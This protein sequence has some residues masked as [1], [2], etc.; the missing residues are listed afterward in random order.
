MQDI[1]AVRDEIADRIAARLGASIQKAEVAASLGKPTSDLTAYDYYLRGRSLRE[2]NRRERS[3][4]A[5]ALFEKAIELAPLFAPAIAELAYADYREVAL[6]WDPPHRE[7]VLARGLAYAKRALATDPALPLAHMVTGDLLLRRLTHD[8][9]IR[10]ARRAVE[11]NPSEAEY[12]AGLAN[13]LTFAGQ[14]DEA[15]SLM[16][17]AFVLDPLHPPNY[18]MYLARAL[19]LKQRFDEALPHLRDC[20]RRAP[21][22]WSCHLFAA[23]AYAHLGQKAAALSS[24][25]ELRRHSTIRSLDEFLGTGEYISRAHREL[26]REGLAKA[27]PPLT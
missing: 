6:R 25:E 19:L 26:I 21:D 8:E 23:V 14:A 17:R 7:K 15:V 12:H 18:D 20:A 27:G 24:V 2:T 3:L 9:A 1:F 22:Y 13:I 5:S 10:W 4:E 11:L 16:Q